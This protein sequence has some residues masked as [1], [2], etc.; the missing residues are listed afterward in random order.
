MLIDALLADCISMCSVDM[1]E[2]IYNDAALKTSIL[3]M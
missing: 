3:A 2:D 1:P